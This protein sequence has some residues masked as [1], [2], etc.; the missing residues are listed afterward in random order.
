MVLFR[1]RLPST[2]VRM[3]M[4]LGPR[5]KNIP[6]FAIW[7]PTFLCVGVYVAVGIARKGQ[8]VNRFWIQHWSVALLGIMACRMDSR[9]G[10][11]GLGR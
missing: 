1:R 10:P 3:L 8:G 7:I 6:S 4:V 2:D 9:S 5:E 11:D